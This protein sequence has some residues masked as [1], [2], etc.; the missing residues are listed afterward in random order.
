M[1][2]QNL[3]HLDMDLSSEDMHQ[4]LMVELTRAQ[5]LIIYQFLEQSIQPRGLEMIRFT[6]DLFDRLESALKQ[7]EKDFLG[8]E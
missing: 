3:P 2:E 7:E 8:D 6:A 1:E 4:E 5:V